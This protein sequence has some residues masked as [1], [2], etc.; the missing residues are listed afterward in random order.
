MTEEQELT[1]R[2]R[3]LA[4]LQPF[5]PGDPRINREG[6]PR[7]IFSKGLR[8]VL[9]GEREGG[10][11]DREDLQQLII[12]VALGRTQATPTQMR[13]IEFIADRLEGRPRQSIS[14]DTDEQGRRER[15]L[16][17]FLAESEREGDPLTREEAI[18]ILAEE[19]PGF[20]VFE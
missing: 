9:D 18:A 1:G 11:T 3:S 19:D 17:N 16:Q 5:K 20:E 12:D 4:N 13:A 14:V 15:K 8:A 10:K 6:R 7:Q 2:K